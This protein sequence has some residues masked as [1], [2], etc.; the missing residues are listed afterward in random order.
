MQIDS[1]T[2]R[3]GKLSDLLIPALPTLEQVPLNQIEKQIK[4]GDILLF[5]GTHMTS[6]VIKRFSSSPYSHVAFLI[7]HSDGKIYVWESVG[8]TGQCRAICKTN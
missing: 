3:K 5:S 8:D 1:N 2:I 6:Q 4:T 7:K